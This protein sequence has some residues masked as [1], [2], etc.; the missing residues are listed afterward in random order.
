MARDETPVGVVLARPP[1]R[2]RTAEVSA[3]GRLD[4]RHFAARR[5]GR[6]HELPRL[7]RG[8]TEVGGIEDFRGTAER[9]RSPATDAVEVQDTSGTV[10]WVGRAPGSMGGNSWS[11]PT[12]NFPDTGTWSSIP[13]RDDAVLK[14]STGPRAREGSCRRSWP[15]AWTSS[16]HRTVTSGICK[17]CFKPSI[18]AG[19]KRPGAVERPR[20]TRRVTAW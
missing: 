15:R 11:D 7:R 9:F 18:T 14:T 13:R 8:D 10:H 3:R 17:G 6:R 16:S 5:T 19:A 4:Q 1:R 20:S 2:L 12:G